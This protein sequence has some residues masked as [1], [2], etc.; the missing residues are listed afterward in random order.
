MEDRLRTARELLHLDE[1]L[2][3]ADRDELF[4]LLQEVMSDPKS[5]LMPA[6]R[7]FIDVKL[8]KAPEWIRELILDF[9]AKTIAELTKN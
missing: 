6:K 5:P 7:K 4:E 3:T 9:V 1:E 8:E 2:T